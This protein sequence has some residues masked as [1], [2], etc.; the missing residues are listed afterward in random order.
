MRFLSEK[1]N[2]DNKDDPFLVG[3]PISWTS[4]KRHTAATS[5]YS[6]EIQAAFYGF[7]TAR[8]LKNLVA[9]LLFGNEGLDIETIAIDYNSSVVERVRSI[10]SVKSERRLNSF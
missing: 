10:N 4:G 7:D 1:V 3:V 5:S 2:A 8:F 6:D 9:E